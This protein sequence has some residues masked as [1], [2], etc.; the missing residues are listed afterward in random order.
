MSVW[1]DI[2]VSDDAH[3][4]QTSYSSTA[5]TV[6]ITRNTTDAASWVGGFRFLVPSSYAT[7][8]VSTG[9]TLSLLSNSTVSFDYAINMQIGDSAPWANTTD[10]ETGRPW[11][12]R[13][14][15][16]VTKAPVTGTK[17]LTAGQRATFTIPGEYLNDAIAANPS[18][19]TSGTNIA[20][21]L[22][23]SA[24]GASQIYQMYALEHALG[25]SD[26]FISIN[27][28]AGAMPFKTTK[29]ISHIGGVSIRGNPQ[30]FGKWHGDKPELLGKEPLFPKNTAGAGDLPPTD[31]I[32]CV[33]PNGRSWAIW[34][35][36]ETQPQGGRVRLYRS[37]LGSIPPGDRPEDNYSIFFNN[38]LGSG[39]KVEW[40]VDYWRE[41]SGP[42]STASGRLMIRH[43]DQPDSGDP[44][45]RAVSAYL[46]GVLVWRLEY[47]PYEIDNHSMQVRIYNAVDGTA[48][49]WSTTRY[50]YNPWH[51]WEFQVSNDAVGEEIKARFYE[52][53]NLVPDEEMSLTCS[54][55]T[56]DKLECGLGPTGVSIIHAYM[57]DIEFWDDYYLNGFW[58]D[59]RNYGRLYEFGTW[60]DYVYDGPGQ[61]TPV[62][63]VG[64]ITS[65]DPLIIDYDKSYWDALRDYEG[66][67]WRFQGSTSSDPLGY[68]KYSDV[69][70]SNQGSGKHTA[71]VFIPLGIP[72]NGSWPVVFWLHGGFFVSGNK[73]QIPLG[74]VT[75]LT[76]RGIAVISLN[77][78]LSSTDPVVNLA[79][80]VGSTSYPAWNPNQDTARHP[81]E[82]LD[83][84]MAVEFFMR[85]AQRTTYSLSNKCVVMGHSAGGYPAMAVALTRGLTNDGS[86]LSYRL[87]DHIV[88]YGYP[89]VVDPDVA[90]VYVMSA[91]SDFERLDNYDPSRPNY[92]YSNT[93]QYTVETTVQLYWGMNFGQQPTQ[94][95]LD[96]SK[97]SHMIAN[98]PLQNLKPIRYCGGTSD[99]LVPCNPIF[100]DADQAQPIKDAY[101]AR[102]FGNRCEIYRQ[103]Q[104]QH[105]QT[106]HRYD[107]EHLIQFVESVTLV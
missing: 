55:V 51:R 71:D 10:V 76:S 54:D 95:Q 83:Y 16:L 11:H 102:G 82:I 68:T 72:P 47:R 63:Y 44:R 60:Q 40:D 35:A 106:P 36:T 58:R 64:R 74:F 25:G 28:F 103:H 24:L 90:G 70:Y 87:Q 22:Y 9:L 18:H 100:P 78:I 66:E 4:S 97:I 43:S 7:E 57:N 2:V 29:S 32:N 21:L 93:G 1:P 94:A 13:S 45:P 79:T 75:D 6:N 23:P 3:S 61:I 107:S 99:W 73:N 91:P 53:D 49:A 17:S 50:L 67:R 39:P 81:T 46:G 101:V 15:T 34:A 37:D 84:K 26:P 92:P 52:N 77:I 62:D 33:N 96:G 30:C 65:L 31:L 38:Y 85:Q 20:I 105:Y 89:N 14:S 69:N 56:F 12:R 42:L 88:D 48:S 104:V 98:A 59:E 86:G 8:F 27:F 5:T 19:S 80:G 41:R